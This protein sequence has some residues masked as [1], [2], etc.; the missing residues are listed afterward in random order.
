MIKVLDFTQVAEGI[1]YA[2]RPAE[3]PRHPRYQSSLYIHSER[4][5]AVCVNPFSVDV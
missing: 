4:E 2:H 5:A 1:W 3:T